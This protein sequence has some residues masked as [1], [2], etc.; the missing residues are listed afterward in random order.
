MGKYNASDIR[1]SYGIERPGSYE[2]DGQMEVIAV[3]FFLIF[4]LEAI[5]WVS[6]EYLLQ[7]K[8]S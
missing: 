6:P 2:S 3:I 5:L 4:F 1:N 8:N 7:C